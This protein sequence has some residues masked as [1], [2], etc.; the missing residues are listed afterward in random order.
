MD[1]SEEQLEEEQRQEFE[2]TER[3]DILDERFSKLSDDNDTSRAP[4]VHFDR[5]VQSFCTIE[6]K[7]SSLIF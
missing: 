3:Q 5:H 7:D 2:R 6:D 4:S 1:P